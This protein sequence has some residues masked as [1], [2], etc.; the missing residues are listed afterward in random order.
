[1]GPPATPERVGYSCLL[2]KPIPASTDPGR[3]AGLGGGKLGSPLASGGH[4]TAAAARRPLPRLLRS[5][6]AEVLSLEKVFGNSPGNLAEPP[7][8]QSHIPSTEVR[9]PVVHLSLPFLG[10]WGSLV[11]AVGARGREWG[12]GWERELL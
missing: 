5:N 3:W 11:L 7:R 9:A 6:R 10:S 4:Q 8:L 1:M 2:L 12:G